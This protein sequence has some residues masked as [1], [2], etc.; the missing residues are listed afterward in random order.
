MR[1]K[2]M[3]AELD[4]S[5]ILGEGDPDLGDAESMYGSPI[6]TIRPTAYRRFCFHV[7]RSK[8]EFNPHVIQPEVLTTLK[9][10]SEWL[11]HE[12]HRISKAAWADAVE[13]DTEVFDTAVQL[14]TSLPL[15]TPM[16]T[17]FKLLEG[18]LRPVDLQ[19]HAKRPRYIPNMALMAA[20]RRKVK[21]HHRARI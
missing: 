20:A 15:S 6:C 2:R 8:H 7:T 18:L 16:S 21:G 11:L 1:K 9:V 4:T 17:T 19:P 14:D 5:L 13:E 3:L 12:G 10:Q